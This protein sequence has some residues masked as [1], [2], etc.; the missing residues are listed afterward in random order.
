MMAAVVVLRGASTALV[1]ASK[2]RYFGDTSKGD[3]S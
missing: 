3:Q 2:L 1:L